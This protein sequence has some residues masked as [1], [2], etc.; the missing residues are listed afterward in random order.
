MAQTSTE[1][2]LNFKDRATASVVKFVDK[3]KGAIKSV[4]KLDESWGLNQKETI[5][6]LKKEQKA[7]VE[8]EKSIVKVQKRIAG[9]KKHLETLPDD[10]LYRGPVERKISD[11]DKN[12]SQLQEKLIHTGDNVRTL[13][14]DLKSQ[15]F[16]LKNSLREVIYEVVNKLYT[17]K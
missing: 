17:K 15:K 2:V 13:E 12:L 14:K 11:L 16:I 10:K 6:A 7:L 5:E 4:S 3:I 9:L 8:T 1:W